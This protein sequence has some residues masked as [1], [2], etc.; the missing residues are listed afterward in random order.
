MIAEI[1]LSFV[2]LIGAGLMLRTFVR[3][4]AVDLGF[5]PNHVLTLK[6]SLPRDKY[7]IDPVLRRVREVPVSNPPGWR[8]RCR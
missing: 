8:A 4:A 3:L 7:P 1:A 6:V 2:L 5:R